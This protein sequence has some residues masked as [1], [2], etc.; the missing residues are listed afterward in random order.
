VKE[1]LRKDMQLYYAQEEAYTLSTKLQDELA[2][3]AALAE[4]AQAIGAKVKTYGPMNAEGKTPSGEA[5]SIP[6]NYGDMVNTAFSLAENETS[7]LFETDDGSYYAIH[8]D[9]VTPAEA[10][11]FEEVKAELRK[12]WEADERAD[13]LHQLA[14]GISSKLASERIENVAVSTG[15]ELMSRKRFTRASTH[16]NGDKQMLPRIFIEDLF[17]KAPGAATGAHQMKDG[18]FIVGKLTAVDQAEDGDA[19]SKAA[20]K[21]VQTQLKDRFAAELYQQYLV[22]LERKH[23]VSDVNQALID[24]IVQ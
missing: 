14:T 19:K 2:G 1:D 12:Q 5:V 21:D 4:A 15:A 22:Y 24:Q 9:R 10:R 6:E 23:G 18:S 13:K 16:L 11:P 3:G 8:M 17:A 20:I 7:T